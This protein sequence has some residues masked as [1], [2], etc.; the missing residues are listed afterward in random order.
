M[1]IIKIKRLAIDTT[2]GV[3][4]HEKIIK[5]R[6][7]LSLTLHYDFE[8]AMHSDVLSDTLDYA[9]L[10]T[11][12]KTHLENNSYELI[13]R[14]LGVISKKL[15]KNYHIFQYY[16]EVAKPS[17]LQAADEVSVILDKRG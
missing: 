16:I 2:I 17:A 13:E 10:T 3:Y 5:Q 4:A 11:E 8:Q 14:I 12:I 15:E 7:Y 1:K 6:L 9:A